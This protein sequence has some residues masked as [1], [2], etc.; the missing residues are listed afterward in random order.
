MEK[1]SENNLSL[2]TEPLIQLKKIFYSTRTA[3]PYLSYNPPYSA[4]K[5]K[6]AS[7]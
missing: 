2:A 7:N 6:A 3:D 4:I 1:E 5:E